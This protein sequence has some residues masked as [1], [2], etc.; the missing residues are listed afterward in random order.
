MIL[1]ISVFPLKQI[2]SGDLIKFS[3]TEIILQIPVSFHW[4]NFQGFLQ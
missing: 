3:E 4:S 1:F 2:Q